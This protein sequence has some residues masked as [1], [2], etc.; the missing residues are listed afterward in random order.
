M[1]Q[2]LAYAR[3]MDTALALIRHGQ[4][5]W[6][7]A[8]RMQGRTDIE[9]NGTGRAQARALGRDLSGQ[10]WDL[11][12]A[13]PLSRAQETA[14]LI[15][16]ELDVEHAAPVADVIERGFGP[17]EG[18]IMAEVSEAEAA[19][20][21]AETEARETVLHRMLGAL[22]AL[23]QENP[24][25]NILVISHGAAM[26]IVRDALAGVRIHEGVANGELLEIDLDRM[27]E[28][29]EELGLVTSH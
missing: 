3:A 14:L 27:H 4:T 13:S 19:T 1:A 9:L 2:K 28:L 6:N 8:G 5:D 26:R 7:L 24:G 22:S 18:R 21:A 29:R 10:N 12:V 16:A 11:V 25:R 20:L 15:A 23:V 17:L